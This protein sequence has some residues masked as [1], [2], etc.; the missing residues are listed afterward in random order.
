MV[1]SYGD[2][3]ITNDTCSYVPGTSQLVQQN[4][5]HDK[6]ETLTAAAMQRS[7][8]VEQS[9]HTQTILYINCNLQIYS[10]IHSFLLCFSLKNNFFPHQYRIPPR[11]F[12][13]IP[14][15]C[16]NLFNRG[17]GFSL[18]LLYQYCIFKTFPD[19]NQSKQITYIP[20]VCTFINKLSLF[21]SVFQTKNTELI[22]DRINNTRGTVASFGF[23]NQEGEVTET[24]KNERGNQERKEFRHHLSLDVKKDFFSPKARTSDNNPRMIQ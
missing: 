5:K 24:K 2:G 16:T 18:L 1:V 12:D 6:S 17:F 22:C 14:G 19:T 9:D 21:T 3:Y 13:I 23:S 8:D 10:F 15:T 7:N 20:P 11:L 4:K